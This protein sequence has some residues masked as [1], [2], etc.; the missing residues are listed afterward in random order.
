LLR[1]FFDLHQILSAFWDCRLTES[2][3]A[4]PAIGHKDCRVWEGHGV[5]DTVRFL[6][7]IAC[8]AGAVYGAAWALA[9]YPPEQT[10]IVRP[11]P[12]ERLRQQ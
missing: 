6:L 2:L 8:L 5:P 11:L 7:I 1:R 3:G 10:E 12:H 4:G 9:N